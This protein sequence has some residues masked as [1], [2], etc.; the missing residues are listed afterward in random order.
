MQLLLLAVHHLASFFTHNSL[1]VFSSFST[2][3]KGEERHRMSSQYDVEPPTSGKVVLKTNKG[4]I[5]IE[6][7]TKGMVFFCD[8]KQ[9]SLFSLFL[10][11][12]L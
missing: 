2:V 11:L 7:W 5:D 8:N 9:E 12:L 10:F 3:I 1:I 4:D 6:L